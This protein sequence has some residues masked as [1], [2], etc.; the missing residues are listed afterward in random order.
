MPKGS[1]L[2]ALRFGDAAFLN[3]SFIVQILVVVS[4]MAFG[5]MVRDIVRSLAVAV[6]RFA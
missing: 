1:V 2:A 6:P 3:T 5:W 4:I